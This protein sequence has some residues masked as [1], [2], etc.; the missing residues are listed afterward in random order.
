MWSGPRPMRTP[1]GPRRPIAA[2]YSL[3]AVLL[4]LVALSSLAAAGFWI[5]MGDHWVARAELASAHAFYAADSGL[6]TVIGTTRGYPA[7]TTVI[8]SRTDTTTVTATSLVQ[9]AGGRRVYLLRSRARYFA[10]D[11]G[12]GDRTVTVVLLADP[13]STLRPPEVKDGTWRESM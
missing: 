9:M 12:I 3:I 8:S 5:A 10:P 13:D 2:G 6:N 1:G 7:D 4:T 11:G